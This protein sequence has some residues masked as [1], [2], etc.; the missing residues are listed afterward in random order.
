MQPATSEQT[1]KIERINISDGGIP[2]RS[3]PRA[4]VR[5]GGISG[6]RQRNLKYHG[7]PDRAVSLWSSELIEK[8]RSEGHL[9]FAGAAGENLTLRGFD[10][11]AIT[12]G[13]KLHFA[14]GVVLE[15]TKSAVPCKNLVGLFT[16]GDFTRISQKLHSG[17]ARLYSKVLV[18]G[19]IE[20]GEVVV[21]S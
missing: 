3:V 12:P 10:W 21:A 9:V 17:V 7:G 6:D 14:G 11:G 1:A 16:D 13:T 18:E 15:I 19:W 4:E 8:L 5:F 2:K 20:E